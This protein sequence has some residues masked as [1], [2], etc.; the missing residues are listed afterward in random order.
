MSGLQSINTHRTWE[1]WLMMLCGATAAV[2]PWLA[3]ENYNQAASINAVVIGLLII[4]IGLLEYTVLQRWEEIGLVF[5]GLWLV[6][7]PYAFGYSGTGQL[8]FWHFGVGGLVTLLALVQFWQD[9]NFTDA[10]LMRRARS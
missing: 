3:G 6:A 7:A 2:S 8:R 5:V 9:R 4:S 10:E 1:D